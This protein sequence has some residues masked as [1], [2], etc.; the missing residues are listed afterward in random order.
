M[1]S[2]GE[3]L[4]RAIHRI[5]ANRKD[6]EKLFIDSR[7]RHG[8]DL[9]DPL[10]LPQE[11]GPFRELPPSHDATTKEGSM[12]RKPRREKSANHGELNAL[13]LLFVIT[14]VAVHVSLRLG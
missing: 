1:S 7:T 3:K 8:D 12:I 10:L 11:R 6:V 9:G 14:F 5:A 2:D 13:L 4:I